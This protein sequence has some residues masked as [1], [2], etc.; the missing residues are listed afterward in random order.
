MN[1]N[2]SEKALYLSIVVPTL[3]RRQ[4][5][6]QLLKSIEASNLESGYEIL[7]VDQNQN[8]MIDDVINEFKNKLPVTHYKVEFN[9]VSKARNYGIKK[10]R[11]EVICFPDD[12]AE[13]TPGSI[14]LAIR[15]L[16]KGVDCIFGKTVDKTTKQ[17][18]IMKYR[19]KKMKLTLEDFERA[20]VE[21]T[22]F[23]RRNIIEKYMFDEKMGPGCIYGAQEG[24]DV[25]YRML[26]EGK[27]IYYFPDLI[28]Y[29]PAKTIVRSSETEVRRAFYYSCGDGHLCK[30]HGLKEKYMRRMIQLT[31]GIPVIAMIRHRE[32]K[33]YIAQWMGMKLGYKYI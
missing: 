6:Q 13:Y 31:L 19:T 22:M 10:S 32:T 27:R 8:G 29:H 4:E 7:I 24:Y 3:G 9:G 16:K 28:L 30:K 33:Y 25:I 18:S 15:R 17:D 12:D 2:D 20:F 21:P 1:N 14:Q 26:K 5:V 23:V 11:G